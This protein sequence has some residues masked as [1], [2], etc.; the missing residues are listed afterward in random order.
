MPTGG[1]LTIETTTVPAPDGSPDRFARLSVSDTG[2]GMTDEVKAKMFEPFFTTKSVGKGTGLGLSVVH[3]VVSQSGGQI[4]IESTV[5]VG[6]TFHVLL[7][8]VT[9]KTSGTTG[10][11]MRTA[12]QGSETVLLVEDE[13]AVRAIARISL[14]TQGYTVLEADGGP[15]AIRQAETYQ[16]EIHLLVTDVVMP[17]MGGRQLLDAIRQHRPAVKVLFMS[18]YTDDAVLL[19]GVIEATDAFIQKPFTPLSLARKVRDVLNAPA[20]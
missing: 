3:G 12:S 20:K 5:G 11:T 9:I 14:Q 2:H 10:D 8:L 6:T 13:Q 16:G 4:A 1:R 19:H 17:E 15:E 7:P 18:G